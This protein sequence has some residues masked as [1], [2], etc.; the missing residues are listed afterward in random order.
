MIIVNIFLMATIAT[1]IVSMLAWAI[2][3]SM[4][5]LAAGKRSPQRA[6]GALAPRPIAAA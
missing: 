4:P 1:V 6:H 5:K 3:S 2:R